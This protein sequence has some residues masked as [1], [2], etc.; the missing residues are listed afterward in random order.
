MLLVSD[1]FDQKLAFCIFLLRFAAGLIDC[2]TPSC[3]FALHA[4]ILSHF[5]SS[6][7]VLRTCILG[8]FTHLDIMLCACILI[9]WASCFALTF[10]VNSYSWTLHSETLRNAKNHFYPYYDA[11]CAFCITQNIRRILQS[12]L[13]HVTPESQ[14]VSMPIFMPIGLWVLEGHIQTDRQTKRKSFF[15]YKDLMMLLAL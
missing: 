6:H 15:H 4:R 3:E 11:I 10:S 13:P 8:C 5:N 7:S 1:S 9:P 2:F 12:Y 14:G